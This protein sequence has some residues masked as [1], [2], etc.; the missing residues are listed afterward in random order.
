MVGAKFPFE[1][2]FPPGCKRVEVKYIWCAEALY[3]APESFR[4]GS[5]RSYSVT[6][7]VLQSRSGWRAHQITHPHQIVGRQCEGKHPA[8][9]SHAAMTGLTQAGH[10]LEPAEDFFYPFTFLLTDRVARMTSGAVIDVLV[11]LHARWGVTWW[12]RNACTNSL[13]S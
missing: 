9:S 7:A 2:G 5:E 4:F 3:S 12:S 11:D 1:F 10:G 13:L 8:H 6:L